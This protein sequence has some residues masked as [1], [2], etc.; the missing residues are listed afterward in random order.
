MKTINLYV[1]RKANARSKWP[2]RIVRRTVLEADRTHEV[3]QHKLAPK[4]E[5]AESARAFIAQ[6]QGNIERLA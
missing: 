1:V 5:T 3:R 4:F 6:H 2:Y